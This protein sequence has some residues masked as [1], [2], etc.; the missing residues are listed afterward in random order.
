[1]DYDVAAVSLASPPASAPVQSYRPSVA[2]A[3]LGIHTASVTG[4]LRIYDRDAGTLLATMNLAASDIDPGETRNATADQLWEPVAGDIGKAF[5]FI[6]S[7]VYPEDQNLSNNNLSPVTV[8]VTAA[9]PPPPPPVEAHASQH[10]DGGGDEVDVDGLTGKLAEA[11]TPTEHASN[12]ESGGA[13]ELSVEDLTG[14][15]AT[16]QTPSTHASS[17]QTGGSDPI[18]GIPPEAHKTNH[19]N[20]GT[21]EISVAGLSGVLADPQNPATHGVDH[22]LNGDDPTSLFAFAGSETV[23]TIDVPPASSATVAEESSVAATETATG[24]LVIASGDVVTFEAGPSWVWIEI[25]KGV[26]TYASEAQAHGFTHG[27][28]PGDTITHGWS[29][30]FFHTLPSGVGGWTARVVFHNDSATDTI[31]VGGIELVVLAIGK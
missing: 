16:P 6:A 5:L 9:P 31:T 26:T 2:V 30:A 19:Q 11:Q 28:A 24:L 7:I 27:G 22:S 12:H 4:T 23:H 21:D 29:R 14:T 8:T 20:G 18:T 1:M 15:L 17:H 3:N 10:E 25:V 13:D